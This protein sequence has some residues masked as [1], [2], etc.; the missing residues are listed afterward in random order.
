[1]KDK[2][3]LDGPQ[4]SSLTDGDMEKVVGGTYHALP[5]S[6][7]FRVSGEAKRL[8]LLSDEALNISFIPDKDK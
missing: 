8:G 4:R 1:M 2:E 3:K 6:G 5:G 7:V